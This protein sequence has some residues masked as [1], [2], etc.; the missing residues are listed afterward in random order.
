MTLPAPDKT[1]TR[2]P[3]TRQAFGRVPWIVGLCLLGSAVMV[4]STRRGGGERT[5]LPLKLALLV[6]LAQGL[7][8]MPGLSRSGTTIAVDPVDGSPTDPVDPLAGASE[9]CPLCAPGVYGIV[10]ACRLSPNGWVPHV[11]RGLR[12]GR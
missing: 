2:S 7:A 12:A 6:G 5:I 11:I 1:A 3:L 9:V 10:S 8:V 4:L